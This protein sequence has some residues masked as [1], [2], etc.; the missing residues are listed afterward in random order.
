[1]DL[2]IRYLG[3][4]ANGLRLQAGAGGATGLEPLTRDVYSAHSV[5]MVEMS[6]N[7]ATN[8][9]RSYACAGIPPLRLTRPPAPLGHGTLHHEPE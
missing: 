9:M 2:N 4:I 1:M 8:H 3:R 5:P 6:P 7:L